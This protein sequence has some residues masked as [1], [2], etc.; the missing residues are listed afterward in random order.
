M[1]TEFPFEAETGD[2][3]LTSVGTSAVRIDGLDK[4][5][6]AAQFVD[7]IDFGP[8][9]LYAAIVESPYAYAKILSIDTAE[10]EAAKGVVRVATGKDFPYKFGMYMEDRYIF[11]QDYVRFVGEQVAGVVA[12]SHREAVQA[13]KLISVEYEVL[14]PLLDPR[15]AVADDADLIHPDLDDYTHVPWFFPQADTNIAHWRK[16]RKG[17]TKKAFAE[18][19]YVLE[20]TY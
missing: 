10:A 17:D 6:G 4:I 16:I 14:T 5:S 12:R 15:S 11:A 20:D 1:T 7:D 2:G 9:L 8:G 18:A 19:D 13:A 3:D